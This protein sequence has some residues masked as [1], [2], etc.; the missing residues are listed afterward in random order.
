VF[1]DTQ[2]PDAMSL[3][4]THCHLDFN[5]YD[6]DRLAVLERAA[7]AGVDHMLIPGITA[8]SSQDAVLLAESQPELYAAVGVHPNEARTW[9]TQTHNALRQLAR[10]PKVVAVG[11]IGLDFYRQSAPRD[12]QQHVL[13]EQ[14][15]MAADLDLPVILHLREEND[16]EDGPAATSLIGS[17]E[18]WVAGLRTRNSPLADRPGVL[19]SFSGSLATALRAIQLGFFI[20]V[21]GPVTFKNTPRRQEVVASLPPERI[22]IETDAP[23]LTPVPHRGQRNEPAYVKYIAEKIAELQSRSQEDVASLTTTN[24]GRLFSWGDK[25]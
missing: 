11:E 12:L 24:A 10:S 25:G 15:D 9:N 7:Q 4:D 5:W 19:H 16:G 6:E 14:L 21:T 18:A 17:L 3:T 2:T 23:F 1:G 20:G 13:S 8:T 22:L